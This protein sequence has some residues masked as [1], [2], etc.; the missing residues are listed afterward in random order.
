M[1]EATGS[2]RDAASVLLNLPGHRVLEAVDHPD[3]AR[4]VLVGST[5]TEA[6]CPVCG[7]A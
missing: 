2:Q 6:A 3:G 7:G 4:E 1:N 5:A